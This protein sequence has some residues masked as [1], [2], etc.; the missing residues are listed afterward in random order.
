MSEGNN[1]IDDERLR[2]AVDDDG[3]TSNAR[4]SHV[5]ADGFD[6]R[7]HGGDDIA[8]D[9]GYFDPS[10]GDV[11]RDADGEII[12][13]EVY[14]DGMGKLLVKPMPYGTVQEFF[15][16]GRHTSI[17]P[18]D[19]ADLFSQQ[20]IK[21]DLDAHYGGSIDGDDVRDMYP[22]TPKGYLTAIMEAS[23]VDP[24]EIQMQADGSADVTVGN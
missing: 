13:Q 23:N 6:T 4:T 19:L 24:Q 8:T 22:L 3:T 17:G 14:A 10:E 15:G 5:M 9:D 20:I 11:E 1:A 12:P 2:R 16:S 7:D 21:P 18:D